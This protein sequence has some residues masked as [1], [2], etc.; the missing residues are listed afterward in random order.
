[1]RVSPPPQIACRSTTPPH[2]EPPKSRRRL[3]Q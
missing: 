3:R 2:S 1:L